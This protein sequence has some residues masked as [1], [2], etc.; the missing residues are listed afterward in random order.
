M[1]SQIDGARFE[2]LP[3]SE[4][5]TFAGDQDSMVDAIRTFIGVDQ[6]V[7]PPRTL[8]RAVLFTDIVRSTEHLAR[9]GDRAWRDVLVAHDERATRTIAAHTGRVVKSTGDGLLATFE[10]PAQAVRAARAIANAVRPDLAERLATVELRRIDRHH[11]QPEATLRHKWRQALPG[12]LSGL[13]DLAATVHQRLRNR[14]LARRL[15]L[16]GRS[17][18]LRHRNCEYAFG[19]VRVPSQRSGVSRRPHHDRPARLTGLQPQGA[20]QALAR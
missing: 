15:R 4:R 7:A 9:I 11:R 8:L 1:A 12:I 6:P 18:R 13:L 17:Q 14:H 3:G 5:A 10:G 19:G 2:L 16:D 20:R